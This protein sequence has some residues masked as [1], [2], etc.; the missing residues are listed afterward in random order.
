[1]KKLLGGIG[2]VL[3]LLVAMAFGKIIGRT[4]VDSATKPNFSKELTKVA[5]QI[6]ATLPMMVDK[7]TRLDATQGGPGKNFSYY[8]TLPQYASSELDPVAV[9]D[10]ISPLV[11]SN[12]CGNK[13]MRKMFE[14]G[15]TA[16]YIYRGNDGVEV[17]RLAITP[18][19]CGVSP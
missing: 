3:L 14:I 13:D 9:K 17:V 12:V 7:D 19:D 2:T 18:A 5:S 11:R 8:Y 6:N 1:M 10:A 15:V 16:H 4:A